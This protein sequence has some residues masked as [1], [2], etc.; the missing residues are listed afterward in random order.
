MH[1]TIKFYSN[2][3][4]EI[5]NNLR[6]AS[7]QENKDKIVLELFSKSQAL[8]ENID[9]LYLFVSA[10]EDTAVSSIRYDYAMIKDSLRASYRNLLHIL[11]YEVK[12]MSEGETK[13]KFLVIITGL[14]K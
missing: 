12:K 7:T 1:P 5:F 3:D 6:T 11:E 8:L 4:G 2:K 9:T 10:L 13:A 14:Q